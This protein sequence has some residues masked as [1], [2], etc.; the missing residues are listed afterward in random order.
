MDHENL[1]K[2]LVFPT[3]EWQQDNV[4]SLVVTGDEGRLGDSCV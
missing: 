4:Q 3:E 2:S 1:P